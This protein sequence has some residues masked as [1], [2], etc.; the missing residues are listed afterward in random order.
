MD[1]R[2]LPAADA[3]A[4]K[5]LSGVK[6]KTTDTTQNV[7]GTF[8]MTYVLDDPNAIAPVSEMYNYAIGRLVEKLDSYLTGKFRLQDDE[9]IEEK[10]K[11][12]RA[13]LRQAA[14]DFSDQ[15]LSDQHRFCEKLRENP[16]PRTMAEVETC[17]QS[18]KYIVVM[19]MRL[20]VEFIGDGKATVATYCDMRL[21]DPSDRLEDGTARLI[22]CEPPLIDGR[23]QA[24]H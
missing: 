13:L 24:L 19:Y 18:L 20:E 22:D 3:L 7:E 5:M 11:L 21:C 12:S 4:D 14:C 23:S 17:A 10:M 15:L 1:P 2:I 9:S 8:T 6:V 16:L